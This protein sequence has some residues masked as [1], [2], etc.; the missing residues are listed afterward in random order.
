MPIYEYRCSKCGEFEVM[1]RITDRPLTRC[2][3]CQ[4]K[5]TKLISNST[6]Q[7]KGS[8]WYA[9]DYARKDGKKTGT[10]A[11]SEGKSDTGAESTGAKKGPS[12]TKTSKTT[13]VAAA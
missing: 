5:V 12:D 8:G 11:S 13:E 1:Q 7:L 4:S 2:P 3:N 9:T 10:E 6:F